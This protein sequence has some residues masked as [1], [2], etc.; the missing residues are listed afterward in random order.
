MSFRFIRS[1]SV[2]Q[3]IA[4]AALTGL[5]SGSFSACVQPSSSD[6]E[7]VTG[8]SSASVTTTTIT[9]TPP[10]TVTSSQGL[11]M[12]IVGGNFQS[13][14]PGST[15]LDPLRI[16]VLNDGVPVTGAFVS[17]TIVTGPAGS[18][19]AASGTT[20]AAGM[21]STYFTPSA[22][23]SGVATIRATYN[24]LATNFTLTVV[25]Q[26][27]ANLSRISGNGQSGA[28]GTVLAQPF[29]VE[30]TDS[31]TGLPLSNILIRFSIASGGR[32]NSTSNTL[33]VTTDGTGRASV[34]YEVGTTAGA[35]IITATVVSNPAQTVTFSATG[36]V[37]VTSAVDLAQTSVVSSAASLSADGSSTAV[38]TLTTRDT[39]GNT[40]PAGG[41]TVV[42]TVNTGALVG[43]VNDPGNGTYTQI[44]RAPTTTTPSAVSVTATVNGQALTSAAAAITLL[45][46]TISLA[47]STVT[48]SA[49]LIAANGTSTALITVTLK[50]SLGNQYA[51]GGQNVVISATDGTLMG[52]VN[53]VGNGTYTQTL[54]SSTTAG[55]VTVSATVGGLAV[56]GTAVLAFTPNAPDATK[57]T[58]TASPSTILPNGNAQS[59][60]TVQLYD[61]YNNMCT[62]ATSR[63]ITITATNG[64][65]LGGGSSTATASHVG[66][67]AYRATLVAP[68]TAGQA[69]LSATD[70]GAAIT[71]TILVY[72][73]DGST[74]PSAV[75]STVQN[76]GSALLPADGISA[77]T[78]KVTL[79]NSSGQQLAGG[80]ANVTITSTAGTVGAIT[81]LGNGTYQALLTAP[82]SP[83]SSA[84][85]SATVN[86]ENIV[87]TISVSFYGTISL[88]QSALSAS[89]SAIVANG[90]STTTV[91]LQARDANGVN[92]PAGGLTDIT[93]LTTSGAL[94]GSVTDNGN[95]VYSQTL[96]SQSGAATATVSANKGVLSFSSTTPVEFYTANNLAGVTIDCLNI[97][98]YKNTNIIVDNGTLT[99][100]TRGANGTCPS[101]FVFGNIILQ[102]S[103]KIVHSSTT[104][105]QEYGLEFT[106]NSLSIDS[107]SSIN[108][109]GRGYVPA[110]A[111]GTMR[112][113]GNVNYLVPS[114]CAG[115]HGGFG[116][117]DIAGANQ[118]YGNI[119]EPTDLG[120]SGS[121]WGAYANAGGGGRVK[122]TITG[123]AGI[124]LDGSIN[125][126]GGVH[127]AGG[128]GG[129][130]GAG[131]SIWIT[132]TSLSGIGTIKANGGDGASS[133][134][135]TNAG[136]GGRIAIYYTGSL[137]GNFSYPTNFLSNAQNRGGDNPTKGSRAAPG[138][139]Y[140]KGPSNTYGDLIVS[141]LGV[142]IKPASS[143]VAPLTSI[144][145]PT[146][147]PSTLLTA[148]T[149]SKTGAFGD[150][151]TTT[152]CPYV[153]WYVNPK[154]NQNTTASYTDDQ[155][156]KITSCTSDMLTVDTSQGTMT[157]I[158][159]TGD[160][161]EP[162]MV[163]D[164]VE[165]GDG[166]VFTSANT[167]RII[168][169]KGDLRSNDNYT[170]TM[171]DAVPPRGIE[172]PNAHDVT[173]KLPDYL[174]YSGASLS[175]LSVEK[176]GVDESSTAGQTNRAS[177]TL[178][179]P[180]RSASAQFAFTDL[181]VKNLTFQHLRIN[182]G[183]MIT[184]A[185][186]TALFDDSYIVM[187]GLVGSSSFS[188][189]TT[190]LTLSTSSTIQQ[191]A[192]TSTNEYSLEFNLANL[193]VGVGSTITSA[194]R[195]FAAGSYFRV[196]GNLDT[197]GISGLA[198]AAGGSHGGRGGRLNTG[199]MS[200][201]GYGNFKNPYT[202]GSSSS[203]VY[204]G[205]TGG[206]II[207][208]SL[209]SGGVAQID[210]SLS[211]NGTAA[212][213]G[214]AG[215]AGGSV[216]I[217][218][219]TLTGI[220]QITANGGA[221]GTYGEGG[222][223]R[224]AAYYTALGGNFTYPT[225]FLTNIQAYGGASGTQLLRGSAG[226]VF[227][228]AST[229][230]YGKLI[231][232][233]NGQ[234][235]SVANNIYTE[236]NIPA[237]AASTG[238]TYA[239]G[240]TALTMSATVND[241]YGNSNHLVGF[242]VNPKTSQNATAKISDDTM[243]EVV[244]QSANQLTLNGDATAIA[245]VGDTFQ[246][247]L[248][249]DE[250]R[251]V[252][253]GALYIKNGVVKTTE[254]IVDSGQ[255]AGT[256]YVE[257]YPTSAPSYDA[258]TGTVRINTIE[259]TAGAYNLSNGTFVFNGGTL[260][261]GSDF[262]LSSATISGLS[263]LIV[264]GNLTL[265]G[266][267][268]SSL[269]SLSVTG[270]LTATS[271]SAT[272]NSLN[273]TGNVSA[274]TSTLTAGRKVTSTGSP[275]LNDTVNVTVGGDLTLSS[276]STLTTPATNST[277]EYYLYAQAAN[278]T[279]DGT[280]TIDVSGKGFTNV[281]QSKIRTIGNTN[282]MLY[283]GS[284]GSPLAGGSYGG[285]GGQ[286]LQGYT[287]ETYGTFYLPLYLGSSGSCYD[288][289]AG[290]GEAGGGAVRLGVTGTLLVDGTIKAN[291]QNTTYSAGSGGSIYI[292]TGTLRGFGLIQA[293]G[294]SGSE[295]Y[296]GNGG[297]GRV[298]VYYTTL[299]D[300]FATPA[301][302]VAAIN[303]FGMTSSYGGCAVSCSSAAGTVYLKSTSQTYGDLI[304]NNNSATTASF[305]ATVIKPPVTANSTGMTAASLTT[306]S[307]FINYYGNIANWLAGFFV[308]PNTNQNATNKLSD[309][310]VYKILSNDANILTTTSD[311]T[312]TGQ[313]LDPY[314]LYVILDNLSVLN[315]ARLDLTGQRL[316][317]L[318]GD[319]HSDDTVTFSV[320]GTL[321]AQVVDV[322]P[323]VTWTN[324]A[325]GGGTITTKCAQNF[326]CP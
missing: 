249:L 128:S 97:N 121:F 207:R 72:F 216:Y 122:V 161:A 90:T 71:R 45:P 129:S 247:N 173:I 101:D 118:L 15:V 7:N 191:K 44:I 322:G 254:L 143:L 86:G 32:L 270:N 189:P 47:Q 300:G 115:S 245:A 8:A 233:N 151:Y 3:S 166:T 255:I 103:G 106:A 83:A 21:L 24:A 261:S 312:S 126:T 263:S 163:F 287:N 58:I 148:N 252:N 196:F 75:L 133:G 4:L 1:C 283:G 10:A 214:Y 162:V 102:N 307:S 94:L 264:N 91:Y 210:G 152:F 87:A 55:N 288:G 139:I 201:Y 108:L 29:V 285:R 268:I 215:A 280:S 59:V 311:L 271:S 65:W 228:K 184:T 89:P 294:G 73:S 9:T 123:A 190:S 63:T 155:L 200:P 2:F 165:I 64:T 104:T 224:V 42:F 175:G 181:S 198:T 194:S 145:Y 308:N 156:Y 296:R 281:T 177:F 220:G 319:F 33:S 25:P 130:S 160:N 219:P 36:T 26:N 51:S 179:A 309:D 208:V 56:T 88:V 180:A 237:P 230:T 54:R 112:V 40:I 18:F 11:A 244:G 306:V 80:G 195:G 62:N 258:G 202:S 114:L 222:G 260:T 116:H 98:T 212:S 289:G 238:L 137:S 324:T 169:K 74:G 100:N 46:G 172:Y 299:L 297:G 310:A 13:T 317:V 117:C 38:L 82:S 259:P 167:L 234:M 248:L 279:V 225:N 49:S 35:N 85:V 262:S 282:A 119:F 149:L 125:V 68:N 241:Y 50:D 164:N 146:I 131:G 256:G 291:G 81:D 204:S 113:Q 221:T 12:N 96:R 217:S 48:A 295:G 321:N 290:C 211:A 120:A 185:G 205:V 186:T 127:A 269:P 93:F 275:I 250:L 178:Y 171:T 326:S 78:I 141:N 266:S 16:Q 77:T 274:T 302:V 140:V 242:H 79:K 70:N 272:L 227:A 105:T 206:G 278:V 292:S 267:T 174:I 52:A 31:V 61:Q 232:D 111:N 193:N 209:A 27:N 159:A 320:D 41:K 147:G 142:P 197:L 273:V 315:K 99:M 158:A 226:T 231:I 187:G 20:D 313:A 182:T 124:V 107:T 240:Q 6:L 153:G 157:S 323:G 316:Y 144:R 303:A 286:W 22:G 5:L 37:P 69:T 277:T 253:G 30:T 257:A 265:T 223:G 276:T 76:T 84:V 66:N 318:N 138:T 14:A 298:A 134:N 170:V 314:K 188:G 168:S 39:Y 176:I 150:A 17:F 154:T 60:I 213:G 95:G 284:T 199:H 325:N 305:A 301:Q 183:G 57:A 19:S 192:T 132:T 203:G 229:D 304:V 239:G 218:A 135:Y 23:T 293:S 28:V 246:V 236:L 53:D 109:V 136:G 235:P 67:G 110:A 251:V 243:F 34:N 92:I 43:S